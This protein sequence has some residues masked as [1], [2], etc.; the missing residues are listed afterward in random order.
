[1]QN[2]IAMTSITYAMKAK[3][4]LNSQKIRCDIVRTPKDFSS[5][6][7]YSIKVS[8]EISQ[9]IEILRNNGIK[10]KENSE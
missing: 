1:M 7:G 2:L 10:W 8:G 3:T 9:I 4:L 6:C 5:G